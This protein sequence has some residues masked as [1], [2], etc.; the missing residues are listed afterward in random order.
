[1]ITLESQFYTMLLGEGVNARDIPMVLASGAQAR[2]SEVKLYR[3]LSKVFIDQLETRNF[4]AKTMGPVQREAMKKAASPSVRA[5]IEKMEKEHGEPKSNS[6]QWYKPKTGYGFQ[7]NKFL[8]G[9]RH[10]KLAGDARLVWFKGKDGKM[11]YA[12][13]NHASNNKYQHLTKYVVDTRN[14]AVSPENKSAAGTAKRMNDA[15]RKASGQRSRDSGTYSNGVAGA[16]KKAIDVSKQ[17]AARQ[18]AD[19]AKQRKKWE[20]LNKEYEKID[21]WSFDYKMTTGIVDSA[22]TPIG[23]RL[24]FD[25]PDPNYDKVK[26]D[27][28]LHDM[29][30][31]LTKLK[32]KQKKKDEEELKTFADK[33]RKEVENERAALAKQQKKDMIAHEKEQAKIRAAHEKERAKQPKPERPKWRMDGMAPEKSPSAF[34]RLKS[35]LG[36]K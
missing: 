34:Q 4:D 31:A 14:G 10:L 3:E 21:D 2:G 7:N 27:G 36:M 9:V 29:A 33:E 18:K 26:I 6:D 22:T 35:T 32:A 1:M 28:Y 12:I 15:G 24:G 25:I 30:K 16:V 17:I 5:H 19:K 13:T 11:E 8:K 23:S 20:E